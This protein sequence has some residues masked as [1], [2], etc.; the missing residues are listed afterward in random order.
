[1][2][3]QVVRSTLEEDFQ[4]LGIPFGEDAPLE[5]VPGE[6][7]DEELGDVK[8]G[9]AGE[10]KGDR[11]FDEFTES[12]EDPL[13]SEFVNKELFDRIDG[14]N[15]DALMAEDYEE[16]I[17]ELSKKK[18]PDGDDDLR[19]NAERIVRMLQEGAA[20]RQRRFKKLSTARKMA[21]RC[22]EGQRAMGGGDGRPTCRPAHQVAGGVGKLSRESRKKKK[23]VR[24]GSGKVSKRRSTRAAA[25]RQHFREDGVLSPLAQELLQV[26]ESST[27]EE[28]MGVRDEIVDRIVNIFELLNEEFTDKSVTGIFEDEVSRIVDAYEHER[29]EEDAMDDNEFVAELDSAL[30]L[31]TKS[32]SMLEDKDGEKLGNE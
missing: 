17:D 10:D 18:L 29:L 2:R 24:S 9:S 11:D 22:P 8:T 27:T 28:S 21:F 14:L 4:K 32:L 19:E 30:K 16:L 3:R 31:I 5:N 15:H 13:E 7:P 6:I 12:T 1:M 23:W 25:R 20:K 26:Q